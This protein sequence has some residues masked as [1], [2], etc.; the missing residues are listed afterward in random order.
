MNHMFAYTDENDKSY[1]LTGMVITLDV[2]DNEDMLSEISLD[3]AHGDSIA[4]TPDFYFSGN[5]RFSAKIAWNEMIKQ[6]QLLTAMV[7]GNVMC[8]YNV[9]RQRALAS[10]DIQGIRA[11]VYDEGH[12]S[13]ALDDDEIDMIYRKTYDYM[14][15]VFSNVRIHS[16]SRALASVIQQRRTLSGSEIIEQLSYLHRH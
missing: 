8:R 5:P 3:N 10:A 4:F 13:C 11:I 15:S 16:I 12:D 1:G 14:S 6:Y 7:I 2:F 9:G